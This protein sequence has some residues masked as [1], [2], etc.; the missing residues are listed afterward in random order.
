MIF[1]K[2]KSL[3]GS[4]LIEEFQSVGIEISVI[5]DNGDGTLSINIADDK[6]SQAEKIVADHKGIDSIPTLADK[7]KSIGLDIDELKAALA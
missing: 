3:N 7:L 6:A 4:Q 1:T 5:D 2:P